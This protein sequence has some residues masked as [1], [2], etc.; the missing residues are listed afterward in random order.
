VV[1]APRSGSAD[2]YAGA[3]R[4]GRVSF[5]ASR[6]TRAL[7][8]LTVPGGFTG[9]VRVVAVGRAPVLVDALLVER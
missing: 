3:R 2:V 5:T 8:L 9:D 4:V 7:V 1:R 6:T